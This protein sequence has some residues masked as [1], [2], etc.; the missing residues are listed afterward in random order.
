MSGEIAEK[1]TVTITPEMLRELRASVGSGEY[2]SVSEAVREAVRLW[3]THRAE[4]AE[5]A[6]VVRER[7]RRSLDDPRPSLSS[8]EVDRQLAGL[9]AVARKAD[10]HANAQG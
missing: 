6:V 8:D 10:D 7:I 1:L 2:G 5:R 9:F 3:K 4:D